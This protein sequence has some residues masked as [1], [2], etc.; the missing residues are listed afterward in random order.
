MMSN[1]DF[2]NGFV[3][4]LAIKREFLKIDEMLT[5][6]FNIGTE[7]NFEMYEKVIIMPDNAVNEP[8]LPDGGKNNWYDSDGNIITFPFFPTEDIKIYSE[9]EVGDGNE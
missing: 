5:V 2:Q 8:I 9:S 3:L 4:G 7:S 6:T 1:F